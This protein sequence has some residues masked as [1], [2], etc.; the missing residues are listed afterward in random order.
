M[1]KAIIVLALGFVCGVAQS[2]VFFDDFNRANTAFETNET[3]SIGS[4]YV[5]SQTVGTRTAQARILSGRIQFNQDLTTGSV[6]ANNVVLR[7]TGIE[8]ANSEV[9]DSFTVSAD[10]KTFNVA[11]GTLL[12][13][14]AFNYQPDGSFYAARLNTG[15]AANVLQFIRVNAAGSVGGFGNIANSVTLDI[16]SI[17]G[18]TIQSSAVGVFNY[19]LTGANLDGGQLSGT[20]T[21]TSL[22]LA[23]GKAGFY[24]SGTNTNPLYDNLSITTIPEPATLGLIGLAA[25]TLLGLR[26]LAV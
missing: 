5:L 21:D 17:Y 25:V 13:G 12:Y 2:D 14:L 19:T 23:N 1:K 8:L 22:N 26:R 18:L 16:D 10:I 3:V 15:N 4:G 11:S 6:N 7:Q 20:A 24:T 9:G